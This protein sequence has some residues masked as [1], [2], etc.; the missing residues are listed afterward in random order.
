MGAYDIELV[1]EATP[2]HAKAFPIPHVHTATLKLEVERLTQAGTKE[3]ESVR[4]GSTYIYH[5]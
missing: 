4:M 2:Y 1:P 3:G 5:P